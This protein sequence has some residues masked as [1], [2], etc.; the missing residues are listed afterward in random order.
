SS[1]HGL[2]QKQVKFFIAQ[3]NQ[4]EVVLSEEH[5]GYDYLPYEKAL[6]RLTFPSAKEVLKSAEDFLCKR[7]L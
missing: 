2:I 4:K 3:T 1:R 5:V 6:E 7:E